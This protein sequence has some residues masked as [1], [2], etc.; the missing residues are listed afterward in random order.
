MI[1]RQERHAGEHDGRI[2]TEIDDRVVSCRVDIEDADLKRRFLVGIARESRD[3]LFLAGI[4]RTREDLAAACLNF[5]H[6]R[7]ELV[8]GVLVAP[9]LALIAAD[10]RLTDKIVR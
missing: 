3:F 8:A 10:M 6:Q 4:E 7:G 1:R 2:V 9:A 5:V